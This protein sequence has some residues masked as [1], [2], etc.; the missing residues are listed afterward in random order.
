MLAL[1]SI[2]SATAIPWLP[3]GRR[4]F[5]ALTHPIGRRALA[6]RTSLQ[7]GLT[8]LLIAVFF[9]AF[10]PVFMRISEVGPWATAFWRLFF[11]FPIVYAVTQVQFGGQMELAAP[12]RR[13]RMG[14][15][16][17][18]AVAYGTNLGFWQASLMET[19]VANA[20]LIA[21]IHPI[22]VV[23][24][25]WLLLKER[26]TLYFLL[27]LVF[28]MTGVVLLIRQGSSD[29]G[30]ISIGDI[31]ALISGTTFGIWVICLRLVR[32]SF[33]TATTTI[34]NLG[35]AGLVL[36]PAA[37]LVE[38]DL[39]PPTLLGW[40]ILLAF[41]LVVNVFAQSAFVYAAG[42]LP[43]SLN[44]LGLLL[45]PVVSIFLAWLLLGESIT[46]LQVIA[47]T[48]VLIGITLAQRRC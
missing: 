11:A 2:L 30:P 42:H 1:S 35:I 24:A 19:S 10:T 15:I 44:S 22:V 34:W 25:A 43:A 13:R 8:A 26:I 6:A 5:S 38:G 23:L 47:G 45:T 4:V 39:A 33:S 41:G 7:L 20:A 32:Q 21:N 14:L 28:S 29:L 18:G 46:W 12:F 3:A 16:A 36:L 37:L 31:Y 9:Y 27:G 17:L 40:G 48:L